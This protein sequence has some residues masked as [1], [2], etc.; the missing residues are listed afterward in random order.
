MD[1]ILYSR[2]VSSLHCSMNALPSLE[3]EL[4]VIVNCTIPLKNN[5][6]FKKSH[7]DL[8]AKVLKNYGLMKVENVIY[9]AK[10]HG[11]KRPFSKEI[12]LL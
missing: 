3:K 6:L 12:L 8:Q 4:T 9:E 2:S 5:N 11:F 1:I 7:L 10:T